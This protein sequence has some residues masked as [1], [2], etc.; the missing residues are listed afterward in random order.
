MKTHS[1]DQWLNDLP[2][3]AS[4]HQAELAGHDGL[5]RVETA[6]GR[7]WDVL[8]AG[9]TVQVTEPGDGA[10]TCTI[11]ADESILMDMLSGRLSPAKALLFGKVKLKGNPKPLLALAALVK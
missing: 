2:A 11:L 3:L 6:Q 7:R 4:Q 8:L 5:F 9:G 1:L 10:P